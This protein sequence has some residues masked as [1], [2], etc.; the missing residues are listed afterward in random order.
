MARLT[1][2]IC[3]ILIEKQE[4]K[5]ICAYNTASTS[6]YCI[7][8]AK[9]FSILSYNPNEHFGQPN[10]KMYSRMPVMPQEKRQQSQVSGLLLSG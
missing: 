10:N 3:V 4:M 8:L 5:H 7:G 1:Q 2:L 6:Y 9:N